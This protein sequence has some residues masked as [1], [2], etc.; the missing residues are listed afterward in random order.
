MPVVLSTVLSLI[1]KPLALA[2][3]SLGK[4]YIAKLASEKFVNW[5]FIQM[6]EGVVKSTKT[7]QDDKWLEK[8]KET[9]GEV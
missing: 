8:I 7:P 2:A 5:A 6:A 3:V 9:V 1:V 4:V